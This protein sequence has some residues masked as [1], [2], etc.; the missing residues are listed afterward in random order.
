MVVEKKYPT[1][2]GKFVELSKPQTDTAT[3]K[4]SR[5]LTYLQADGKKAYK[6]VESVIVVNIDNAEKKIE[7][8]VVGDKVIISYEGYVATKI[9][10]YSAKNELLIT[11]AKPFELKVGNILT[12]KLPDGRILDYKMVSVPEVTKSG[13]KEL[14]KGDIVK[15]TFNFGELKKME[16]TG[17]VA[18]DA[19]TIRE[20]LISDGVSKITILNKQAERKTYNIQNKVVVSIGETKTNIEGLYQLRIGQEIGLEMDT[21]GVYNLSIAK[22][23]ERTKLTFTLMEVVKDNLIKATDLEGRIWVV[24]IKEGSG[25]LGGSFKAGDRIEVSGTKLS[26]QLFEA[27]SMVKVNQ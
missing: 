25:I 5:V 19:G 14:K 10:A 23:L 2:E 8:L 26:D 12:Y 3:K 17:M 24:N 4:V 18:E 7:D 21:A 20:L 1:A 6:K 16:S 9:E 11:L 15:A 13:T 27:E 22:V